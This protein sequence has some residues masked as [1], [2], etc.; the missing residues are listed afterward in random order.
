MRMKMWN[1]VA[2]VRIVAVICLGLGFGVSCQPDF[3]HQRKTTLQRVQQMTSGSIRHYEE[4][5]G[6][7]FI[8]IG[9]K[10]GD[11]HVF[12]LMHPGVTREQ[13]L[14]ALRAKKADLESLHPAGKEK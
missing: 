14:E 8:S 3:S 2:A 10:Y 9:D 12:M 5:Y 11:N 7:I 4:K 13:A 6:E 1:M